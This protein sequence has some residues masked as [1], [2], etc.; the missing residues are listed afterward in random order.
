MYG[1]LNCKG[2]RRVVAVAVVVVVGVIVAGRA[3]A[4]KQ[5]KTCI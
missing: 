3:V 5:A 1:L 4:S 2:K